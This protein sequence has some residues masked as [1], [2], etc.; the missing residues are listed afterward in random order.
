LA[1]NGPQYLPG[2]AWGEFRDGEYLWECR[3][4]DRVFIFSGSAWG[5]LIGVTASTCLNLW[6]PKR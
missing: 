3:Y 1:A 6:L 2:S 5:I 4:P